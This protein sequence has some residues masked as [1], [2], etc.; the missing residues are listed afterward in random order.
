MSKK[1]VKTTFSALKSAVKDR[2][3]KMFMHIAVDSY[4]SIKN[5]Y[6]QIK[7]I[8]IEG[9]RITPIPDDELVVRMMNAVRLDFGNDL[10]TATIYIEGA[11]ENK[12]ALAWAAEGREPARVR[13]P[14]LD[15]CLRLQ[16]K[17]VVGQLL[18][19]FKDENKSGE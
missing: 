2:G 13:N 16:D 15:A 14:F 4:S 12:S 17:A 1:K 7:P 11:D 5:G 18:K 19:Q 6:R 9:K 8:E 3:R 10:K